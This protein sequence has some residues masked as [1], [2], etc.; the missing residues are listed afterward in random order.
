MTRGAVRCICAVAG[1]A[2]ILMG[3]A[4][5]V[6]GCGQIP[7]TD[8]DTCQG[9]A[10]AE[11]PNDQTVAAETTAEAAPGD[12]S[13][14]A[15][16][17]TTLSDDSQAA[18]DDGGS[19][20]TEADGEDSTTADSPVTTA[21]ASPLD[22][23]ERDS[24]EDG[25]TDSAVYEASVS[26]DGCAS[27]GYEACTNG[28]D[29]NCDGL[30]DCADPMCIAANYVC[31]PVWKTGW[32]APVA[33]AT[34]TGT[35][36]PT[37]ASCTG[38]YQGA[39]ITEFSGPTAGTATCTCGC[40][41][42]EGAKC[43]APYAEAAIANCGTTSYFSASVTDACTALASQGG[44]NSAQ[45]LDGGVPSGGTCAPDA[46]VSVPPWS[47]AQPSGWSTQGRICEPT[48]QHT[49][50]TGGCANGQ[51]CVEGPPST[52]IRGGKVC[53]MSPG[54]VACPAGYTDP[55]TFFDGGVDTRG[56]TGSCQ[57][58][59]SG[60]SCAPTVTLWTSPQCNSSTSR[61]LNGTSC[62]NFPNFGSTAVYATAT[63]SVTGGSCA[64]SGDF[65]PAGGVTPSTGEITVCC[66]P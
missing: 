54:A 55:H 12:D 57:C 6:G 3:S 15:A 48:A 35:P 51:V 36:A 14:A 33:L 27:L 9:S 26:P 37:P 43:S 49:Y 56:C 19:E 1:A 7:C 62:V 10:D 52:F 20:A 58:Q 13:N 64:P 44:L 22:A 18:D 21:D 30:V 65:Q 38:L 29:D 63:Q 28:V 24:G 11:A 17:M 4:L 5:V 2:V 16:D 42:V 23:G 46:G 40:G 25:P 50:H 59:V 45:I 53:L 31:A 8:T 34:A 41:P 47:A 61:T 60:L 32:T 39:Q 66:E